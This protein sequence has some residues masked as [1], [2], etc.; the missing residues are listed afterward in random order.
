MRIFSQY[1]SG[2]SLLLPPRLLDGDWAGPLLDID[3][4]TMPLQVLSFNPEC[5]G[6]SV[7]FNQ[8]FD[9]SQL[10]PY[11]AGVQPG[12]VTLQGATR[13]VIGGV[14]GGSLLL[15]ADG[16]GFSFLKTGTPLLADNSVTLRSGPDRLTSASGDL[17]G[18][19]DG[20][21]GGD[22][23]AVYTV[24]PPTQIKIGLPD[25]MRGPGQ[26]VNVPAISAGGL[27]VTLT[28]AGDVRSLQFEI[29][30][31]PVLLQITNACGG[32]GLPQGATLD[33]DLSQS[34]LARIH[35]ESPTALPAGSLQLVM[36]SAMVPFDA[37]YKATHRVDI[38]AVTI[39]GALMACADDDALHIVGYLG[40]ANA[41]MTY[42]RDDVRLIQRAAFYKNGFQA[43]DV[44][45]PLIVADIDG[46]GVLSVTDATR[47]LQ[48]FNGFNRAEI[49]HISS[50]E[51]FRLAAK[52]RATHLAPEPTSA[53]G[54][55]VQDNSADDGTVG[56]TS[57]PARDPAQTTGSN[58]A[59]AVRFNSGLLDFGIGKPVNN[60][61]WLVSRVSGTSKP[62]GNEW[63]VIWP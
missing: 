61:D 7:R 38:A 20:T 41:N 3:V 22:F 24:N 2:I 54:Q 47:V 50:A 8:A 5:D 16:F 12:D 25:F 36:L 43:W 53:P 44:I 14:I 28:S 45:S 52:Q 48:E 29:R 42:E 62:A 57:G 56:G 58:T 51:A 19:G 4:R 1:A 60:N 34:G 23:T 46:N 33:V 18:N 37:P 40:D 59:P 10:N 26:S 21:T 9:Q 15:D 31:D 32:N 27:P 30:Y 63:R 49:P 11:G 39:N 35:I 13:G 6:F 55:S 17:D